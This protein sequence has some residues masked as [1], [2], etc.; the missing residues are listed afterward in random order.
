M[1]GVN[2]CAQDVCISF[3][4]YSHMQHMPIVQ[5]APQKKLFS[6]LVRPTIEVCNGKPMLGGT[7][8]AMDIIK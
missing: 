4:V 6:T 5:W 8:V 3:M 1:R 7:S 2:L